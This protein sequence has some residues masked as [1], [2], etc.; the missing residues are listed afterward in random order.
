MV[1]PSST[2]LEIKE[3]TQRKKINPWMHI[4]TEY[5]DKYL[6]LKMLI[7]GLSWLEHSP[8]IM[9]IVFIKKKNS[10]A[11]QQRCCFFPFNTSMGFEEKLVLVHLIK[12]L[13]INL[14]NYITLIPSHFHPRMVFQYNF[15]PIWRNL[16]HTYMCI[17]THSR[18]IS[19]RAH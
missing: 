11:L 13:K 16:I 15:S 18:G 19:A 9:S 3:L 5:V 6:Y 8:S 7:F 2:S 17:L 12:G 1:L 4:F 10:T 14:E